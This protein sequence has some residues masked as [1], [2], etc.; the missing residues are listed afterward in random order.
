MPASDLETRPRRSVPH[1][2]DSISGAALGGA[3]LCSMCHRTRPVADRGHHA[4]RV[5]AALGMGRPPNE[6][7]LS[8][9]SVRRS[10]SLLGCFQGLA[11]VGL[12][13]LLSFF[14]IGGDQAH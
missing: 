2:L 7:L 8:A 13:D 9:A 12:I 1:V 11:L 4:G 6:S 14:G 3:K 10:G 5:G